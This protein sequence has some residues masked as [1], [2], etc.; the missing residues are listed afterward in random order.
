VSNAPARFAAADV[1]LGGV[2]IPAGATVTLSLAAAN[3]DPARF[4]APELHDVDRDVSGHLAFG[5]GIHFCLGASLARLE[6]EVALGTLLDRY[7]DLEPAVALE[8]VAYRHSVLIHA[9]AALPV[10][11]RP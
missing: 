2:V 8:D 7:P 1:E 4:D 9:L 11:L 6:G 3:R 10:R 5:H